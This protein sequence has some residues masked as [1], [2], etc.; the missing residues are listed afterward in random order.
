ME[1]RNVLQMEE[2]DKGAGRKAGSFLT[3]GLLMFLVVALLFLLPAGMLAKEY[4]YR[5][6]KGDP[7]QSRIYQLDNGLTVY[8]SVNK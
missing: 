8:L 2:N 5:V 1:R 6:V 4:H 7:M 3:C